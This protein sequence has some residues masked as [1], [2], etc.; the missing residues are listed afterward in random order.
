MLK[1]LNDTAGSAQTLATV[2][3]FTALT[4]GKLYQLKFS[5][6]NDG[7][8]NDN[9]RAFFT[10]DTG[11]TAATVTNIDGTWQNIDVVFE[12]QYANTAFRFEPL[13]TMAV[14][15]F[16][17]I[18]NV[19]L[20]EV[21]PGCVASDTLACDGWG[22]EPAADIYREQWDMTAGH[23]GGSYNVQSGSQYSLKIIGTSGGVW[24][25]HWN[26][27]NFKDLQRFCGR[28]ITFGAWVKTDAANQV[29]LQI[30][31]DA[32]NLSANNAGSS[33]EW[34]ELTKTIDADSGQASVGFLVDNTKTAYISQPM[35]VFGSSIGEGNY[36]RPQGEV[37]NLEQQA[38]VGTTD[39]LAAADDAILNLEALTDGKIPK[40]CK[41][42]S[43]NTSVKNSTMADDEGVG[44]GPDS[45]DWYDLRNYPVVSSVYNNIAG[46][47]RCDSNGDIYRRVT[48]SG[49]TISYSAFY[50][51][52]V[53]LR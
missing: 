42:I 41:A 21:T 48:E 40:G 31:D 22:K 28:T 23:F 7:V 33:W 10:G 38:L 18:D 8:A 14:S 24:D 47:I 49:A 27:G 52:A 5:I 3:A 26:S 29:Q 30:Y 11:F 13:S 4:V 15:E 1:V 43:V 37:V 19:T 25:V 44:W 12:A 39:A 2:D 17:L 32:G 36:T 16:Y 46:R 53:E 45:D 34:L 6:K 9:V 50:I 51:L 35:L 20:Y